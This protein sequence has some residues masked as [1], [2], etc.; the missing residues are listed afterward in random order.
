MQEYFV[1]YRRKTTDATGT[2]RLGKRFSMR[3]GAVS[4][5]AIEVAAYNNGYHVDSCRLLYTHP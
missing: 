2:P 4:R 3:V 1:V 5:D